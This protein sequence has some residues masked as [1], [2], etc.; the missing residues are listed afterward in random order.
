M[1]LIRMI[2]SE[3]YTI[4]FTRIHSVDLIPVILQFHKITIIGRNVLFFGAQ[5]DVQ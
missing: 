1:I 3:F 5:K 4:T 2:G